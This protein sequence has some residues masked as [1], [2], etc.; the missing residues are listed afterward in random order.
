MDRS[1]SAIHFFAGLGF[2]MDVVDQK[3]A[4]KRNDFHC[5]LLYNYKIAVKSTAVHLA[6]KYGN[7]SLVKALVEVGADLMRKVNAK[8]QTMIHELFESLTNTNCPAGEW[9]AHQERDV[10]IDS[11]RRT[12][13]AQVSDQK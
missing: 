11:Y 10:P 7:L 5:P 4:D 8:G 9:S 6:A 12:T 3:L 13:N 2:P 1:C